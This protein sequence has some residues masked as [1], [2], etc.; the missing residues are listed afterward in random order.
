MKN[1]SLTSK[2]TQ[3]R[4]R[5]HARIRAKVS[6]TAEKPRMAIFKSNTAMYAQLI[7]DT[8]GHTLAQAN[9]SIKK[10]T[11][12]EKAKATGTELAKKAKD[13][14]I[15][16]VVFDRGGFTYTGRIKAI[17]EGAREGGLKF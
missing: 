4:E 17:A 13:L 11:M 15:E 3:K 12:L 10:G 9:S 2:K 5:R 1:I 7:D 8:K 14:K 16:K 6:G